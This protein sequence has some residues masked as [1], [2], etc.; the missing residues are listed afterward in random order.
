[1]S[2]LSFSYASVSQAMDDSQLCVLMSTEDVSTPSHH[3][4]ALDFIIN[5]GAWRFR[6]NSGDIGWPET[7]SACDSAPLAQP[8]Q[9]APPDPMLALGAQLFDDHTTAP[10]RGRE[11]ARFPIQASLLLFLQLPCSTATS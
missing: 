11:T 4:H 7:S 3:P 8:S 10:A 5:V 9:T 6:R 1:M 2:G